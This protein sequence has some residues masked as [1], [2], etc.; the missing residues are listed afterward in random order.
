MFPFKKNTWT[1]KGMRIRPRPFKKSDPLH[2]LI[3]FPIGPTN[4]CVCV[5]VC[6]CCKTPFCF[7]LILSQA[8]P[9]QKSHQK[10]RTTLWKDT[11]G[12]VAQ[13]IVD[14]NLEL[15]NPFREIPVKSLMKF[16]SQFS[17]QAIQIETALP[18]TKL[19]IKVALSCRK[20]ASCPARDRKWLGI[21][22]PTKRS[23]RR[24][25]SGKAVSSES[26]SGVRHKY[27][28]KATE[29]VKLRS[30]R[31]GQ[32]SNNIFVGFF[33]KCCFVFFR[34]S[35]NPPQLLQSVSKLQTSSVNCW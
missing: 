31:P 33:Q 5:C 6:V 25:P 16:W 9:N 11:L 30:R 29:T 2:T 32:D 7:S 14:W 12:T 28:T 21:C 1:R 23:K 34:Y 22:R 18:K 10:L 19:G 8:H 24:M 15:P 13:N 20:C 26:K 35:K 17:Q 27:S 3:E 4:V